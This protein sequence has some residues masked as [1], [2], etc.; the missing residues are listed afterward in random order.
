[1]DIEK[2]EEGGRTFYSIVESPI[3]G[4]IFDDGHF[5]VTLGIF[6]RPKC[7]ETIQLGR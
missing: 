5:E 1:M 6:L 3:L 2:R 4:H 7:F